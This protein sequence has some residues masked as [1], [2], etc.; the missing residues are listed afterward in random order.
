[1]I[2]IYNECTV[3]KLNIPHFKKK[4]TVEGWLMFFKDDPQLAFTNLQTY[5]ISGWCI[6]LHVRQMHK[7]PP[8]ILQVIQT[9]V[10]I[11]TLTLSHLEAPTPVVPG[12]LIRL[13]SDLNTKSQYICTDF[14]YMLMWTIKDTEKKRLREAAELLK[15]SCSIWLLLAALRKNRAFPVGRFWLLLSSERAKLL[16]L[17]K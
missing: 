5:T 4:Y 16:C 10:H 8:T 13:H 2:R 1:M 14:K 15:S 17:Y 6:S 12:I 3:C 7:C 9:L 11:I